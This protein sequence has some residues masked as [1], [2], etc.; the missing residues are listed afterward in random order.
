[1]VND[2]FICGIDKRG[3]PSISLYL[4]LSLLT[5]FFPSCT[6]VEALYPSMIFYDIVLL[7]LHAHDP[8]LPF[9]F[10]PVCI[11]LG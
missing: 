3:F 8:P 1:M 11:L 5:I 7:S 6:G 2:L 10:W 4:R 9:F